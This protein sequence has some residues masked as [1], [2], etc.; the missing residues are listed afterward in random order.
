MGMIL[1]NL[2][3]LFAA[4]VNSNFEA[5]LAFLLLCVW[6]WLLAGT[7][8]GAELALT[9]IRADFT[10]YVEKDLRKPSLR[11]GTFKELVSLGIEKERV[12]KTICLF[13]GS[14]SGSVE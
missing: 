9:V 7:C 11:R 6:P 3:H 4:E 5:L 14:F 1:M 8:C 13:W 12:N 2:L 10:R